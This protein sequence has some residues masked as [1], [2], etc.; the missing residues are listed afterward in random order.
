MQHSPSTNIMFVIVDV[1]GFKISEKTFSPKELA[2]YDGHTISHYVFKS[3]FPFGTLPPHFQQQAKWLMNNHHCIDWDE[4][5]TP[6]FL[7]PKILERLLRDADVVYVKGCEKATFLRNYT[8]KH[9]IEIE[10]HPALS[11][12]QPSCMHHMQTL[13]YCALSNVYHLYQHYV[14]Q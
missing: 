8:R 10:E 4:G 3:P 13:C 7:F 11:A 1:Q 9:I 2:A 12:S 6:G 5:F 14:M